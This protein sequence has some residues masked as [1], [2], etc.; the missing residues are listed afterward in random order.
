MSVKSNVAKL[1]L[2][3]PL[4]IAINSLAFEPPK[5]EATCEECSGGF[6]GATEGWGWYICQDDGGGTYCHVWDTCSPC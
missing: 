4:G 2:A 5:A 6:C 3:I 1:A